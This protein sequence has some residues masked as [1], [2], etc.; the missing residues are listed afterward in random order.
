[1]AL[2]T[3]HQVIEQDTLRDIR[4][5]ELLRQRYVGI[6][7]FM[8]FA[9]GSEPMAK[10]VNMT[11]HELRKWTIDEL[12]RQYEHVRPGQNADTELEILSWFSRM[13]DDTPPL[14]RK[15]FIA[16]HDW[17]EV[18]I[19]E[20]IG[21]DPLMVPYQIRAA[22]E[23]ICAARHAAV[24]VWPHCNPNGMGHGQ[25]WPGAY[26][27]TWSA[28]PGSTER[29][30]RYI[31]ATLPLWVTWIK[32]TL[33]IQTDLIIYP[34]GGEEPRDPASILGRF[35]ESYPND[36]RFTPKA[37]VRYGHHPD[38]CMSYMAR[39]TGIEDICP[40]TQIQGF[41]PS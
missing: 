33:D 34:K 23:I 32:R 9:Q 17:E 2:R 35:L 18:D 27:G 1:M 13:R 25:G 7:R 19:Y 30:S 20:A 40:W 4:R 14:Y 16:R 11:M 36:K 3:I 39:H 6:D 5:G 37:V 28:P 24:L 29:P 31:A 26:L 21:M 38:L 22:V 41:N 12:I 15:G 8:E 10:E